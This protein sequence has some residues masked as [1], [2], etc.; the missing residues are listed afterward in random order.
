[1]LTVAENEKF[2][3][4]G[5]GTPMGELLR[6]YWHPIAAVGEL[7]DNPIKPVRLLGEDL[8]LYKDGSGHYGLVDRHCPHRRADMSYGW[9]EECGI[10]CNYHGWKFDESGAC[11]HQ[12]FEEIAHPDAKF[13]DRIKIKAYRAEA[14]AGMIFAYMGPEPAPLNPTWESFTYENGFA[15]IV[16]ADLPCNW[17]QSQENSIDPVHFEWLH[18]NWSARQVGRD[19]YLAPGHRKIQFDDFEFGFGYRRILENSGTGDDGWFFPRM[20]ILPNLFAPGAAHFEYKVPIDDYNTLHVV[21]NWDAVPVERRPY[22]QE[23]IPYW[24]APIKDDKTGR[25]I[26]SHV[27]NQDTVAWVGQGI[28]T[29]RENEHLGESDRGVIR[30][31]QQLQRDM[32]AVQRGEDPKGLIRDPEANECI[33]WPFAPWRAKMEAEFTLTDYLERRA[34]FRVGAPDDFFSFYAGQPEHIREEFK[35]AMGIQ[36]QEGEELT[37]PALS[38]R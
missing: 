36:P 5:P 15:Q 11:V 7:D 13:K 17:L 14:K 9:V 29:D 24:T 19:D 21:W 16:F 28:V 1:M 8:V 22:V 20:C 27:V 18:N 38:T 10:R 4:V 34:R 31:R 32:E 30:L 37:T 25:W 12:P 6:R 2:I 35:A 23:R 26:T 33:E 3:R